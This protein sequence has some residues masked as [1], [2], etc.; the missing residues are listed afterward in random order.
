MGA[1]LCAR[2]HGPHWL[3]V[4]H[5]CA[6]H[7]RRAFPPVGRRKSSRWTAA[8]TTTSTTS[9]TAAA[10]T[11]STSSYGIGNI[12]L[13]F[14]ISPVARRDDQHSGPPPAPKLVAESVR[15]LERNGQRRARPRERWVG[16]S[17]CGRSCALAGDAAGTVCADARGRGVRVSR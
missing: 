9:S 3:C 7:H 12:S 15:T 14:G 17:R 2:W 11:V 6:W 5:L 16:R 8:A 4:L 10:A 13:R 1:I